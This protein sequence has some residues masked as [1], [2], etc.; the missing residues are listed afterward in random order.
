M[1]ILAEITVSND[2][3]FSVAALV[4]MAIV[5]WAIRIER[6]LAKLSGISGALKQIKAHLG[7]IDVEPEERPAAAPSPSTKAHPA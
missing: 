6:C 5:A 1:G 3:V 2:A 7:I 4:G